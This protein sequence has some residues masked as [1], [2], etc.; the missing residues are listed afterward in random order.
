MGREQLFQLGDL[1]LVSIFDV[2]LSSSKSRLRNDVQLRLHDR[3]QLRGK[4]AV[5]CYS[6]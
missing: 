3:E 4:L 6:Q 5:D 1:E 2:L